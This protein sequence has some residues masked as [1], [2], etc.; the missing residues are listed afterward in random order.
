M[1]HQVG[2][3]DMMMHMYGYDGTDSKPPPRMSLASIR[4][5]R[6]FEEED[7]ALLHPRMSV[8][9]IHSACSRLSVPYAGSIGLAPNFEIVET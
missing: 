9:S 8:A 4:D 3:S 5:D 1:D 7:G 2:S 6:S